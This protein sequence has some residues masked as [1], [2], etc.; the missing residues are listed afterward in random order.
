MNP[1]LKTAA[2]CLALISA[3][4]YAGYRFGVSQGTS[5]IPGKPETSATAKASDIDPQTGKK[6][7]YWHDPMVPGQRFDKPG[8]SPF[9]DM[10]LVPVYADGDGSGGGGVSI[11]SRVTQNLGIRTVEVK[12]A[13]MGTVLEAPGNVAID[14]R[15]I[16]VIQA[17]TTGFIQQLGV[18][19]A[20]D[21]VRKGQTLVTLYAPDWVAAQEE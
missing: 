19:A 14:E 2:S 6:V 18:R 17:R 3:A 12:A 4:G 5:A 16:Q 7:L 15:S 8:K 21:P 11:D 10:Q 9:M 1:R 13:R 20:L